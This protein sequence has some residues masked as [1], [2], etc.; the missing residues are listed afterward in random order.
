MKRIKVA[1]FGA[2]SDKISQLYKNEAKELGRI[3]ARG[4]HFLLF[5]AGSTGIMG[6]VC[7]GYLEENP[8]FLP[9]GST[10][11]YIEELERPCEGIHLIR[12]KTMARRKELYWLADVCIICPGGLGTMDE[13]FEFMTMK[14]L[15]E[16]SG[17]IY[18]LD[19][20]HQSD[21]IIN[22]LSFMEEIETVQ[23]VND[24]YETINLTTLKE[25]LKC[26]T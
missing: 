11:D 14:K 24:L 13:F 3:L 9:F 21:D 4:N 5:G 10:T 12:C 20:S 16:W 22:M 26:P 1:V 18:V 23:N 19:M 8:D 17:D 6:A 25:K 15:G 7:E 2:A